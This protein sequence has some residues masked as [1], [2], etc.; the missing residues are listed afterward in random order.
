MI[1]LLQNLAVIKD[2][3]ISNKLH[4][5]RDFYMFKNVITKGYG[6]KIFFPMGL[7]HLNNLSKFMS[8]YQEGCAKYYPEKKVH[9]EYNIYNLPSIDEVI[10][11][12]Q[13]ITEIED[14]ILEH[15]D[16]HKDRVYC[17]QYRNK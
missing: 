8:L 12:N 1:W 15:V 17:N 4:Y 10:E 16:F 9:E 3:C 2:N 7:F 5:Q 6:N 13:K 14:K 11:R